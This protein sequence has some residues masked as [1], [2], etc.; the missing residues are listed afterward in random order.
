AFAARVRDRD[1]Q[2]PARKGRLHAEQPVL[3]TAMQQGVRA[4]LTGQQGEIPGEFGLAPDDGELGDTVAGVGDVAGGG[5]GGDGGG[6][7]E[8]GRGGCVTGRRRAPPERDVSTRNSRSWRL[9]C[10]RAFVHNSLVSRARSPASSDW[11]QTTASWATRSRAW[12]MLR[13]WGV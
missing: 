5:G 1:A 3:E 10:S 7:S 8:G 9:P 11:P 4:Q 2:G 13:G 12:G 6:R